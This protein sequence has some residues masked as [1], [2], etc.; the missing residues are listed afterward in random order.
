MILLMNAA[1][2]VMKSLTAPMLTK[3][4]TRALVVKATQRYGPIIY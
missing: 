1:F 3:Y 2:V 4:Y